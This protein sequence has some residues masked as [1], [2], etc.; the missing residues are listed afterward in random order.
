MHAFLQESVFYL[1]FRSRKAISLTNGGL[2]KQCQAPANSSL[3]PGSIP[4]HRHS[5]AE[6]E[7]VSMDYERNKPCTCFPLRTTSLSAVVEDGAFGSFIH[8]SINFILLLLAW[9]LQLWWLAAYTGIWTLL[10]A[11]NGAAE[12][13]RKS[14]DIKAILLLGPECSECRF[15]LFSSVKVNY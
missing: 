14:L 8:R 12:K 15:A 4:L 3:A 9:F 7:E 6:Q 1:F 11:L 2:Q 5:I 10:P 13:R